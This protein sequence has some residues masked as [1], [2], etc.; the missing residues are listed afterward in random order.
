MGR[1]ASD[2]ALLLSVLAGPDPRS[3]ISIEQPGE[4]F[5]QPL[6]WDFRGVRAAFS[7]DFGG[8]PVDRR[9]VDVIER[10]RPVWESIGLKLDDACPDFSEADDA[11][12]A[13][14]AW[15]MEASLGPLLD[16]HRDQ[17]KDTLIWNIE[18]G[19]TLTGPDLGRAEIGRTRL[20]HRVRSFM[21]DR[22]F[23]ILPTVQA[24][25]FD[26]N[27]PYLTEIDGHPLETYL[28]WMKSCYFISVTGLPAV[29]VPAGFTPEGLPVGVQIVGEHH[30]ELSVLRLAHAFQQA[31]PHHHRRPPLLEDAAAV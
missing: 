25:P 2:V 31:A 6:D 19:R 5:R 22:P 27:Q 30:G 20:Y 28:D 16:Q 21:A 3:P 26:V 29:S 9:V 7:A 23:L 15:S 24:P 4:V 10:T 8:L 1:T 17:F 13:W 11:F 18:Q 12:R 14:R